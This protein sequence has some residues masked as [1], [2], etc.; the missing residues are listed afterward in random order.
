MTTREKIEA[1][2]NDWEV[3]ADRRKRSTQPT[4]D[5]PYRLAM[6]DCIDDLNVL[7]DTILD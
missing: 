4:F 1:L 7:L 3:Q 5:I 6:L 2:I